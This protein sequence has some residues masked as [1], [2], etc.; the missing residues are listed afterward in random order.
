MMSDINL[1]FVPCIVL[2]CICDMKK[3]D[4][5]CHMFL[6]ATWSPQ[7]KK[8]KAMHSAVVGSLHAMILVTLRMEPLPQDVRHDNDVD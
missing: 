2:P 5:T 6:E 4:V 3:H 8:S 7:A 1:I